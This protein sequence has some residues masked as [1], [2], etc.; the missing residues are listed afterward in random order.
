MNL[1]ALKDAIIIAELK[2]IPDL[3]RNP[4][5]IMLMGLVTAFPLYFMLVSGGN[6]AYGL[7]GAMVANVS[8]I[9][10][11]AGIQ[12]ITFDRYVKIR[13]MI[14]AM[15]VHPVSYSI[16]VALAPLMMSAPGLV[17]FMAISFGVGAVPIASIGW[18]IASLVLCWGAGSAVGFLVS[19]YL[20]KASVYTLG[21]ISNILGL[22]LVFLPPVYY[23]EEILGSLRWLAIVFPTS[24]ASGLIRFYSGDLPLSVELVLLRWLVL[25]LTVVVSMVVVA[26]K[27][28]WRET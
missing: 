16:G 9:G 13:E 4:S 3:K 7:I 27:A 25:V 24:N 10:I 1:K 14:I 23:P 26:F 2:A 12:D 28:K 8:F 21:N 11:I 19:A 15:P 20:Q 17:L 6:I 22:G 5:M 18:I